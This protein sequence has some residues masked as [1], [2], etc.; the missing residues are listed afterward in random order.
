MY[1]LI[2]EMEAGCVW[3]DQLSFEGR[4]GEEGRAFPMASDSPERSFPIVP[5]WVARLT[6]VDGLRLLP[7][8]AVSTFGPISDC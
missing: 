4:Y 1:T 8:G 2:S 3:I 5:F 6:Q 7:T